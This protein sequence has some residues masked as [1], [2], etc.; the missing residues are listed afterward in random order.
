MLNKKFNLKILN[1]FIFLFLF[2]SLIFA[3]IN[4]PEIPKEI[5]CGSVKLRSTLENQEIREPDV[6]KIC[7]TYYLEKILSFF[8]VLSLALGVFFLA[9]SGILYIV[10]PEKTKDI[11]KRLKLGI[12][13]IIISILSLIIVKTIEKFFISFQQ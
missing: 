2:T 9:W 7:L 3:E 12:L 10:N 4:E 6:W 13:G 1:L 8:Y 5:S 11:H